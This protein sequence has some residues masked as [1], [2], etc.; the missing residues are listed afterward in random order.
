EIVVRRSQIE[1][2]RNSG[3]FLRIA[4]L[5]DVNA[6]ERLAQALQQLKQQS[7]ATR[8]LILRPEPDVAYEVLVQVMDAAR[9]G[10][11]AATPGSA[12]TSS[13]RELFPDIFMG[14]APTPA[15]TP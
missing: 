14:M 8:E 11:L 15:A 7:P 12:G 5:T 13:S 4:Y 2:F 6:F 10:K 3:S 1:L 9:S